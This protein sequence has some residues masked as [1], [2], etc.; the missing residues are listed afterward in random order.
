MYK[1]DIIEHKGIVISRHEAYIEIIINNASACS[2]CHAK[3]ACGMSDVI[4]KTIKVK[5]NKL[6]LGIGDEVI[7]I[8]NLKVAYFAVFMAYVLPSLLLIFLLFLFNY[9]EIKDIL[10]ACLCLVF[11]ATYFTLIYF[12]R[13]SLARK[14]QFSIK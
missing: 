10:A 6:D 2:A 5:T 14:V 3:G 1:N 13:S 7:V 11:V 4:K 12:Y 9:F 8:V